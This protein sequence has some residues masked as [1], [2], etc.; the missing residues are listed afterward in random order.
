MYEHLGY[1]RRHE[2]VWMDAGTHARP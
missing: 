2:K 1:W